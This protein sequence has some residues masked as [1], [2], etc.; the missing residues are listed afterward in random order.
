MPEPSMEI[1]DFMLLVLDAL[2]ASNVEYA[3]SGAVSVWAWGEPRTTRDFDVVINLPVERM[4]AFSKELEK[5]D[6]LVPADIML[7]TLIEDRADIPLN[8]IHLYTGY[9]AD[10]FML[11][12]G[13]IYGETAFARRRLVDLEPPLGEVYVNAPEDLILNKL[14]YY[15]ISQQ[16]KH[17]RDIASILVAMGDE[18]DRTYIETWAERLG[19]WQLWQEVVQRMAYGR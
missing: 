6:M 17:T 7:D 11:R 16:P 14:R 8:A 5:R 12:P 4:M 2:R 13:D 18:L 9:K 1:T 19:V 15:A 3:I 10:L